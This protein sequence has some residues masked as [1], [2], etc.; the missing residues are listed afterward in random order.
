M[1]LGIHFFAG[2]QVS[3][4]NEMDENSK[5]VELSKDEIKEIMDNAKKASKFEIRLF[6]GTYT[7]SFP[8]QL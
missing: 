5:F 3:S 8:Y 1:S 6:S 7:L 2:S 4:T